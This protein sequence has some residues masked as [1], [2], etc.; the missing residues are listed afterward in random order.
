MPGRGLSD[1]LHSHN[2]DRNNNPRLKFISG[3][4]RKEKHS[5]KYQRRAPYRLPARSFSRFFRLDAVQRTLEK[6]A[7]IRLSYTEE[8]SAFC[9]IS[10][11]K[12]CL[13]SSETKHSE[14]LVTAAWPFNSQ[15]FVTQILAKFD[16]MGFSSP[17][18]NTH[19]PIREHGNS[20]A[21]SE[22]TP[23]R[24]K[25]KSVSDWKII[26]HVKIRESH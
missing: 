3:L 9:E 15:S 20:S 13:E 26:R 21:K 25:T 12:T 17:V 7:F 6:H 19:T 23:R 24:G 11:P 8:P 2:R 16:T 10:R 5:A 22:S 4:A 14:F 1:A 18:R